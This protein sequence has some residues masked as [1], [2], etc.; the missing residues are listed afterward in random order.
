ML[1]TAQQYVYAKR[2]R[3]YAPVIAHAVSPLPSGQ[4]C[5]RHVSWPV[6]VPKVHSLL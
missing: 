3:A 2:R 1:N 4:D 5:A 6:R